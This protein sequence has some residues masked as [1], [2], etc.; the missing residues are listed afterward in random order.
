[1]GPDV[2]A[3]LGLGIDGVIVLTFLVVALV[4]FLAPVVGYRYVN[5]SLF[6]TSLWILLGLFAFLF[7]QNILIVPPPG[8]QSAQQ[9]KS[10]LDPKSESSSRAIFIIF[11]V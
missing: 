5:R 6:L 4:T 8:P 7:L 2:F 10:V 3:G 9:Y 11:T 1:M